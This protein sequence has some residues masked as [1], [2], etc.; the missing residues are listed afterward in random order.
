MARRLIAVN[1]D[2]FMRY[3][4]GGIG[5]QGL[6]QKSDN[7]IEDVDEEEPELE[8]LHSVQPVDGSEDMEESD[9][10]DMPV[11]QLAQEFALPAAKGEKDLLGILFPE[12]TADEIDAL[13]GSFEAAENAEEDA[14]SDSDADLD[15]DDTTRDEDEAIGM[16][17]PVEDFGA[18]SDAGPDEYEVAG[19]APL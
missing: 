19:Y 15:A 1:R 11:D 10:D 9:S 4:G 14:H 7:S 17:R 2:M 3:Y 16:V 8:D 18:D 12:L 5:H 6:R 13:L